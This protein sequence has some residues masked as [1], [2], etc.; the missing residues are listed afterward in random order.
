M[1]SESADSVSNEDDPS[2]KPS[3][4]EENRAGPS[5]F[6]DQLLKL[7]K[8]PKAPVKCKKRAAQRADIRE[9]PAKKAPANIRIRVA[10]H[11]IQEQPSKRA[12]TQDN[13]I[14]RAAKKHNLRE[15]P[16]KCAADT[17]QFHCARLIDGERR[18]VIHRRGAKR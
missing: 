14:N 7:E 1:C 9:P 2:W 10:E 16:A 5:G 17:C 12:R 15:M 18:T 4:D 8:T 6:L 13:K 11:E 3:S